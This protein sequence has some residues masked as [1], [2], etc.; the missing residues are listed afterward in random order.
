MEHYLI[1][2]TTIE[3]RATATGFELLCFAC[4]GWFKRLFCLADGSGKAVCE[5]CWRKHGS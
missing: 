5:R 4:G 3:T 1:D 2:W